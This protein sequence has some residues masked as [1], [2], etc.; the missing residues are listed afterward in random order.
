METNLYM[1][2]EKKSD[3]YDQ[4][5]IVVC[6]SNNGIFNMKKIVNVTIKFVLSK[7]KKI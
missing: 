7:A 4:F 3:S 2:R 1:W 5:E 6:N